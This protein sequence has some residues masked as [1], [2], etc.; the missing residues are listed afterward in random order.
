MNATSQNLIDEVR[1]LLIKGVTEVF[2]TMFTLDVKLVEPQN[3]RDSSQSFV[4]GSI[5]FIGD[6]NGMVY[7]HVTAAFARTLASRMLGLPEAEIEGEEMVNDVIGELSNMMVGAVKSQL[8][9]SG[10]PCVLTIPSVVR[11]HNLSIERLQCSDRRLI[12]FLCGTDSIQVEL[13]MKHLL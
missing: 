12:G 7:I 1:D 4:A 13:L 3:F 6:V 9:D 2:S 8:C 5:G 11:G 10:A